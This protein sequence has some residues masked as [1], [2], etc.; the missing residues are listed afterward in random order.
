MLNLHQLA[1][2]FSLPDQNQHPHQLEQYRG[3]WVLVYFYP[4]D[5][6]PGCTTEACSFRDNYARLQSQLVVLGI[7]AD[8]V[9]SHAKFAD[10]YQLP[11]PLLS[12]QSK[13]T[14]KAYQAWGPFTK[15]LSY[16]IDPEGKIAK[17]YPKVSPKD[18]VAEVIHDLGALQ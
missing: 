4:K 5:M 13:A 8:S 9:T 18:H 1:P 15:R 10:K 14:I 16:L 17:A 2:S 6:T 12:D 3:R 11:F 7:S